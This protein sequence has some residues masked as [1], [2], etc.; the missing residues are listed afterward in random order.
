MSGPS[1]PGGKIRITDLGVKVVA[2]TLLLGFLGLFFRD[3]VL[4]T[5]AVGL[6]ALTVYSYYSARVLAGRLADSLTLSPSSL[7]ASMFAGETFSG[8]VRVKN[9]SEAPV[10]IS[11]TG[12]G[13]AFRPSTIGGGSRSVSLSLQPRLSGEYMIQSVE[14]KVADRFG[15]FS[16]ERGVSFKVSV[17]VYP[18]FYEV[19]L[20]A[21][22][23]LVGGD[24]YAMG[25]E[26]TQLRGSGYEYAD[27]RSYVRGDSFE[28]MD[29][30]AS[31]R[32]GKLLV[33][34]FY[35][36]G[37]V[38]RHVVYDPAAP[39]P[40]SADELSTAFLSLMLSLAQLGSN[41][42][43]TIRGDVALSYASLH[44][45]EAVAVALRACLERMEGGL[46]GFYGLLE[47]RARTELAALFGRLGRMG[48][49][50]VDGLAPILD[51]YRVDRVEWG[52]D[53]GEAREVVLVSSLQG[54]VATVLD[55]AWLGASRGWVT[56]ALQPT[57]PWLQAPGLEDSKVSEDYYS[58]IYSALNRAGVLIAVNLAEVASS[59]AGLGRGSWSAA[60]GSIVPR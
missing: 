38:T 7:E 28:R 3:P 46:D 24:V 18:R 52:E 17:K 8:E 15:F 49:V 60:R 57:R 1:S 48:G 10:E 51:L 45:S 59:E 37:G 25:E 5:V 23:F 53:V 19:A 39:D 27:T 11:S 42:G 36:E 56:K 13:L 21:A 43:L 33:K 40:V 20:E 4:G 35:V 2:T 50:K 9:S 14:V 29:W 6:G 31:A 32:L 47:P 58:R 41:L 55:L 22:R 30:K 44:P 26:A 54:D 34:V 12:T 16:G